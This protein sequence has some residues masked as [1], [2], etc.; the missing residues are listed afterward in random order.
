MKRWARIQ[1]EN[2][3]KVIDFEKDDDEEFEAANFS[4]SPKNIEINKVQNQIS[5]VLKPKLRTGETLP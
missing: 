1:R 3:V 2:G 4:G 5:D